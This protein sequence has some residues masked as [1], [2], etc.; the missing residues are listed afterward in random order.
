MAGIGREKRPRVSAEMRRALR[1]F[2]RQDA[3][4]LDATAAAWFA[5]HRMILMRTA[6]QALRDCRRREREIGDPALLPDLFLRCRRCC[7]GGVLPETE[8]IAAAFPQG[9]SALQITLLPLALTCAL[10]ADAAEG[11]RRQ[12]AAGGQQLADAVRSMQKME[13]LDAAAL[14]QALSR[15]EPF[16]RQDP[17]GIY[18]AL[19]APS[20]AAYRRAAARLARRRRCTEAEAAQ[21]AASAAATTGRHIGA[22]LFGRQTH[23]QGWLCL[24]ME[25]LFPAAAAAAIAVLTGQPALG[26]LLFV[27]LA[28][29]LHDP[30]DA[31]FLR[32]RRPRR[33]LRLDRESRLV[34][35]TDALVTVSVLL[36]PPERL[37]QLESHL[38]QLYLSCCTGQI[39]LC[40]LADL[41]Q[42]AAPQLPEDPAVL[43]AA[44]AMI[45]RL[46]QKYGGGFLLAVRPR[47]YSE[48]QRAF[49]GKERKRGAIT[50]L[51]NAIYGDESGFLFLEGD[52]SRLRQTRYLMA[53]DADTEPQ[54]DA[55]RDLLAVALHPLHRPVIDPKK[56]RVTAGYGI[57]VPQLTQQIDPENSLYARLMTGD[58]GVTAYDAVSVEKYQSLFEESLFCGKGLIDTAAYH[59]LIGCLPEERILSHDSLEGGLLRVGFCP[60]VSMAE[61]FPQSERADCR[62][63]DRW[64]RGDWQ[65]ARFIFG[66][67]PLGALT[68][69]RL[70]ENLW[71]SLLP[72]FC[73]AVSAAGMAFGGA[74]GAVLAVAGAVGFA[75]SDLFAAL[76]ALLNGGFSAL[77]RLF[78]SQ[79]LPAAL[80]AALAA[81]VRLMLWPRFAW[82]GVCAAAKAI[83]R[84]AVSKRNLLSWTTAAGSEGAGS[85][86][87]RLLRCWPSVAAGLGFLLFGGAAHRLLGVLFLCAVPFV[88][89][90]GQRVRSPRRQL[91]P[92]ARERLLGYAAAEWRYFE[93]LCTAEH[94]YLPPDN[95]QLAPVR[96]VAARTSP[97]N[98]GLMLAS[99]LAARDFGFIDSRTLWERLDRSLTSVERLETYHG[100]LYNWY[101]TR[102]LSVLDRFVST[103]DSG[104]F[105]CA[106]TALKEGLREYLGEY[107]PLQDLITRIERLLD[108]ADLRVLYRDRRRL[109]AIGR[110]PDREEEIGCYDLFMSEARMTAYYAVARRQVPREHWGA[111]GRIP[112]G[113]GRY[114]GLVSWTGTMFEYFMP[115]LFLPAPRGSLTYESLLFCLYCQR[116]RAGKRPYGISESGYYAFDGQL[117]YQYQAH[118]VQR[119]G[120][121]RGLN[122][123]HVVA[124]YATFLTLS[125]APGAALRNLKRLE[126][127]GILGDCGFYEA[128]DFTPAR[129]GGAAYKIVRSYMAH[130]VGMSLLALDNALFDRQ[131]QR[132]FLRDGAMRG[133]Q[134]LL[135]ERIPKGTVPLR[136]LHGRVPKT[137]RGH[138]ALRSERI[139]AP[140]LLQPTA[141]AFSNGRLTTCI[142]EAG[143]GVT[144]F[145]GIDLHVRS[146]EPRTLPQGVFAVV[147]TQ[148]GIVP[149]V[150]AIDQGSGAAF[151]CVFSAEK[152]EHRARRGR[153]R[154]RMQTEVLQQ[155][156]CEL[157]T[158]TVENADGKP[159]DCTLTV[160]LEPCLAAAA[161]HAAHPAF[162]KL[163]LMDVAMPERQCAVFA[164][165]DAV[166]GGS[167]A[168]AVGFLESAPVTV[169]TARHRVLTYPL[170]PESLGRKP[171]AAGERGNPDACC[172]LSL[173]L[174]LH[175][176]SRVVHRLCLAAGETPQA[177]LHA[178][179]SARAG[180]GAGK[181]AHAIFGDDAME[182][183]VGMRLLQAALFP[184]SPVAGLPCGAQ[185]Q[186]TRADLWSFGVSGDYPIILV[187]LERADP[188]SM[189]LPYVRGNQAMR[190]AG[191]VTD[192]VI[193]FAFRE[194]YAGEWASAVR[195]LLREEGCAL[196][197]GVNGGVHLAPLARYSAQECAALAAAAAVTFHA[198]VS[199]AEDA[200]PAPVFLPLQRLPAQ[201]NDDQYGKAYHFTA[202]EIRLGK[203]TGKH[204]KP[205]DIPW[206]MIYANSQFG[207]LVSD[208]S[209]GFTWAINAHENPLTLRTGDSGAPGC[210]ELLLLRINDVFY[211]LAALGAATFSTAAAAWSG[212][213]DGI[214][215]SFSVEVA[216]VGMAKRCRVQLRNTRPS[217]VRLALSYQMQP[218]GMAQRLPI[219][220]FRG[221]T[222][223]AGLRM[224]AVFAPWNGWTALQ[225][226]KEAAVSFSPAAF[227]AGRPDPKAIV[228]KDAAAA[229]TRAELLQPGGTARCTFWLS[230][231]A[232]GDAAAAMPAVARFDSQ[233][234]APIVTGNPRLDLFG[235][236]FLYHQVRAARFFG[237]VGPQQCAGAFGFRDQLQDCLAI[238]L[239]EPALVRRHLLRC[240][241]VQFSEG[242]VLHWWHVLPGGG[243]AGVRTRCS[244]DLLWLPFV[245]SDY[246]AQTEDWS[247]L[248]AQVPYLD[249]KPLHSTERERYLRPIRTKRRET[250]LEHCLRAAD[251]SMTA[252]PHGLPLIGSCDWN[253][254]FSAIGTA[255]A[256][257]SVWLAMFQICVFRRL[258]AI[259]GRCGQAERQKIL[260]QKSRTL[261]ET[262][263]RVAWQGDHYARAILP[264]GTLLG[265]EEFLDLLPQAWA[266]FAQLGRE[267]RA[268]TALA[269]AYERLYDPEKGLLRLLTPPFETKDRERIGYIAA[270]PPGLRENGGQYTHA[271]VWFA[272]ALLE[273]G[274]TEKGIAL[275]EALSPAVRAAD[276]QYGGEPY[277][278]AADI[279]AGQGIAGRAGWTHYTGS[280]AWY[281]RT[282]ADYRERIKKISEQ[283]EKK[284]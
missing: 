171:L 220:A 68:R 161:Q 204:A 258:A 186:M 115:A 150:R 223:P 240:A 35:E 264:D 183:A 176:R 139:T 50:A 201:K 163:F 244:D 213:A 268:E 69:F 106:L 179:L 80:H 4:T 112:V 207:T 126:Q 191:L 129:C 92:A 74:A 39:R 140:A 202:E 2:E 271:A 147:S 194:G 124:P 173:P 261:A 177:A 243:I 111:L 277:A 117:N 44:Q 216:R 28:A 18:P 198:R 55:A 152:A 7:A 61:R 6:K 273:N 127:M 170:G 255:D 40:C 26:W 276:A 250:L 242:D 149:F 148:A 22:Y 272:R 96:A 211:D 166:E 23:R 282:L 37:G 94:H 73:L 103:V 154:L 11:L 235:R 251:R 93:T 157:R 121:K 101:A 63:L 120:L 128:V 98:I 114:S 138:P 137:K 15:S 79:T 27:P 36:P 280:A 182:T 134:S 132:R 146:P 260:L 87:I 278:M 188:V 205:L 17:A 16:L 116:K 144:M 238:V 33:L 30:I 65:N 164:R 232:S 32:R 165:T 156:N 131:M 53:L 284:R 233:E 70:T 51:V 8:T 193:A 195:A 76:Y 249:A 24:L 72:A 3:R 236:R 228:P 67:L 59:T 49:A 77:S 45:G 257:E 222:L 25:V 174:H 71:R 56:R 279:A 153:L 62:R 90:S 113:Q 88:L 47:S 212:T 104:N 142:T 247:I 21:S 245:L 175:G 196:L 180:G 85:V 263:E 102:D 241:A 189:L 20:A 246:L 83:W 209:L 214:S 46:N 167:A 60:E 99:V 158:L 224:Q 210:G 58:A 169:A 34:A 192:L 256:G 230:W 160:Y 75:S 19:D 252:G 54:F 48:T 122:L 265:G 219:A 119:L 226:D 100:N 270:Y 231:G 130:H 218:A 225:C 66:G 89:L 141:T 108:A 283:E 82:T 12:S 190:T 136:D 227:F 109:F 5:D 135:A 133:A 239:R 254:G 259:C 269:T 178:L 81:G 52:R 13:A 237:R 57:L 197:L 159:L 86:G 281:A 274:K 95:L 145:D 110:Y 185:R 215:F 162:S 262:V 206:S 43:A 266:V 84:Q 123:D 107:P 78:Y 91:S 168:L 10:T 29:V 184:L 64:V 42:A 275:L 105:L 172:A 234:I 267:G 1:Q 31:A 248:Q 253:D 217:A 229:V 143:T 41:K 97:T 155:L 181:R 9:L 14:A 187:Q 200:P 208:K 199:A 38:E 221:E 203:K 125:A 118:G 151:R